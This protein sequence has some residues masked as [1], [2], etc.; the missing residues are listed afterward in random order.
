VRKTLEHDGFPAGQL[1]ANLSTYM[2]GPQFKKHSGKF[3]PFVEEL[4][5]IAHSSEFAQIQ[6]DEGITNK[7]GSEY[8]RDGVW[9]RPGL[10]DHPI[11]GASSG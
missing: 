8:L 5:G 1:S 10:R 9:W 2:F 11:R 7:S 6:E 4:F 3:H